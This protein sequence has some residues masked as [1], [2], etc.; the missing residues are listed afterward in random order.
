[1]EFKG[2][3]QREQKQKASEERAERAKEQR[4]RTIERQ[5]LNVSGD[6][7]VD[8]HFTET[9][10]STSTED[11]EEDTGLA[12]ANMLEMKPLE[13]SCSASCATSDVEN[14]SEGSTPELLKDAET[15]T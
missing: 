4:K 3:E 12:I 7:I 5:D 1:M 15:Q 11:V 10:A 6:R 2:D 9:N 14:Q 13:P 8:V